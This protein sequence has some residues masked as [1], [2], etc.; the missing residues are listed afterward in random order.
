MAEAIFFENKR[1]KFVSFIINFIFAFG[2]IFFPSIGANI[3]PSSLSYLDTVLTFVFGVPL[4]FQLLSI[5]TPTYLK[6]DSQTLSENI[7]FLHHSIPSSEILGYRFIKLLF[8]K[9]VVVDIRDPVSY[10]RT[11]PGWKRLI[12]NHDFKQ[13]KSPIKIPLSRMDKSVAE[14]YEAIKQVHAV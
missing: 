2:L 9:Y 14:I 5:F 7:T 13:V 8:T 12:A 3:L 1:K 4:L 11:L 10:V 6:W